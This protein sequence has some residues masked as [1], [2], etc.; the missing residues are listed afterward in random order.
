MKLYCRSSSKDSRLWRKVHEKSNF[1]NCSVGSKN[2][3]TV[4]H[5]HYLKYIFMDLAWFGSLL[6]I[7]CLNVFQ[8]N[9]QAFSYWIYCREYQRI[10]AE[11]HL[12]RKS[13][14]NFQ[15]MQDT[16]IWRP[17]CIKLAKSRFRGIVLRKCTICANRF[18]TAFIVK[19]RYIF[20]TR[21]KI[22]SKKTF[23]SGRKMILKFWHFSFTSKFS[24]ILIY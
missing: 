21:K 17:H 5:G 12:A 15:I 4:A 6:M 23:F 11:K 10:L 24:K 3:Y 13:S 8:Q 19:S 20:F 16:W 14:V 9:C 2:R 7:F 18:R 22:G 1:S